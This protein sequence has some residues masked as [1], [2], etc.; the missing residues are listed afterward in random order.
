MVSGFSQQYAI[1]AD[2]LWADLMELGN[3]GA[4]RDRGVSRPG[5]SPADEEARQWFINACKQTG[6]EVHVDA[7]RNVIGR[8]PAKD[9]NA[10]VLATGSHLDTVHEG[11]R[12]DGA[13]GVMAGLEC[14][15]VIRENALELPYIFEVIAFTDEEG[16]YGAGS[17]GSRAMMGTLK[18]GELQK[19]SGVT[20]RVFANDLASLGGNASMDVRRTPNSFAYYLELHIEQGPILESAGMDCGVVTTIVGIERYDVTVTGQAGHAGT[21]PMHMRKDALVMAA[22]L[23]TLLPQWAQEQNPEMVATIGIVSVLPGGG[24]IIPGECRFTIGIRSSRQEDLDAIGERLRGYVKDK[25]AF[26][27]KQIYKK[28]GCAMHPEV[29]AAIEK[30]ISMAGYSS[31]ALS[32]GA[33]HDAQSM[34][35]YVPSG[36]I[37]VP[38]RDGLSHNP[39][40]WVEKD[41][42]ARGAQALLNS[43][44]VLSVKA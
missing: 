41:Q 24:N 23:F 8:I 2:R 37:F 35:P 27:V 10:K 17:V 38:C 36:M 33:G 39:A 18:P 40:E 19:P 20:G 16:T 32:S 28:P 7:L 43:F 25:P 31:M 5:L 42:A 21:T 12:F 15:R 26:S 22:P 11:G 34:G 9:P 3:I 29:M 4:A 14:A 6:L 13:L 44:L 30:G 1:N